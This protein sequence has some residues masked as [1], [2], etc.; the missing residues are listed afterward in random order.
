MQS[1]SHDAMTSLVD[2]KHGLISRE[3]FVNDDLYQQEQ[4]QVFARAWLFIGHESQ[5]PEPGDYVTSC[6][7]EESVIL[8]R[9]RERLIHVFLNTC[10]HR[11]M[12]VCRYDEGNTPVFT[13]PYHG[14]S[15]A[16]DGKLV[17]VPHQQAAYRGQLDVS[18]WGLIEVAQ[19]TNY[20]GTIWATWDPEAPSFLDYLG[21]M[22]RYLDTVLDYRDG[23]EGGSEVIGGIQKWV[24]P[25]NWKFAAENFAG[26]SYH[27]IS[28]RSVDLVGIGPSGEGRRDN[29]E[30]K[31]SKRVVSSIPNTGHSAVSI[32]EP[33]DIP[34]FPRY[35]NNPVVMDYFKH[36]YEER[37]RRL[38]SAS[39][40]QGL[41]GT[42]FPNT[43][44]L[45]RQPRTISVWLPR[46][47]TKTEAWRWFLVDQDAPSE[48]KDVMRHYAMRYSGPGGMTEQD[49]M[50]NWNYASAASK[51]V[52][53]RR[54]PYNYEMG[55]G[56]E[57]SDYGIPGQVTERISEHNQRGFYQHWAKLMMARCWDDVMAG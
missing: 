26:D 27:N 48:V 41:V 47:A 19:M 13:C 18:K 51:G 15:F 12:K 22:K 6:M 25:A 42:V 10:R 56:L 23:R 33:E 28:H 31:L 9:D 5:I 55:V 34:F 8:T 24:I 29:A 30:R 21:E 45:A 37:R 54:Y 38:G 16:T 57:Y 3:I 20:K 17:G 1:H 2:V 40:L 35:Q 36:V 44:Y 11:G 49:D 32:L 39:R 14:W 4:E 53:A 52:I 7:G 46:G 50:E 43:S